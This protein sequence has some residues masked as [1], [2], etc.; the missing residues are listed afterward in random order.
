MAAWSP[1]ADHYSLDS[2]DALS[3]G[4]LGFMPRLLVLT[5]LPHR[6]PESQRFERVNGR[7]SLRMSAPGRVGLPYGS[8]PR[9]ILAYLTSEA[10]RTKNREIQLG[11]TPNALARTLGLSVISGPR[12]TAP[13]LEDQLHRLLSTR[14]EWRTSVGLHPKSSGSGLVTSDFPSILRLARYLLSKR[15]MWRSNII[16]RQQ[17]F[18]EIIRTAVPVDLRAIRQL[19]RSPLAIDLYVWLTYRMSY[20]KRP[21]LVPWKGLQG[22]CGS[23]YSRPRDFR[24]RVLSHLESVLRVDPTVRVGATES[25]L[26][27]YRSS[28]HVQARSTSRLRVG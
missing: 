15:P 7:H 4:A 2:T 8:Y 25:G 22:Q 17:F 24:R 27:L 1:T 19:Q 10:V 13:R 26:R 3:A 21:T 14:L 18:E 20:L 9:L 23:D 11:T 5:T 28:P 16:L 12:G 6:R